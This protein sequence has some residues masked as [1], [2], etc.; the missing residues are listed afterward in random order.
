MK[1]FDKY[2]FRCSALGKIYSAKGELTVANKTYLREIFTEVTTG[3]RKE[4]TCK[5]F[6]KGHFMEEDGVSM[7]NKTLYPNE[8]LLKNRQRKTNEWIEGECDVVHGD[9]IYDVK[10]AWDRFTFGKAELTD[11]Y[12]WQGRGYMWL[13]NKPM[14]RL[15][16]CL[17]NMP[18]HL[19]ADE[20]RKLFYKH[21]FIS[22]E[23]R[24]YLRL[25]DELRAFHN[26][27]DMPMEERFKVWE[28]QHSD[29][30]IDKLKA[31]I[32][33]CRTFLNDL[34]TEEKERIAFNRRLMGIPSLMLA[35]LDQETNAIIVNA[36]E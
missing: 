5:I 33:K 23:D 34:L 20:E 26:Y 9:I 36:H 13:W 14:F 6:E 3:K 28:I 25:C 24:E 30:A 7:V 11:D 15:F 4:I 8:L 21:N 17:N 10:N 35:E 1:N 16:Y 12:E 19:L 31:K 32:G 18:D 27:D 29:E 2:R 22:I